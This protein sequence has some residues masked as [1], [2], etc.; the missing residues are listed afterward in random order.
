MDFLEY[1]LLNEMW[2][3][4]P[5]SSPNYTI[6]INPYMRYGETNSG[7]TYSIDTSK[8]HRSKDGYTVYLAQRRTPKTQQYIDKKPYDVIDSWIEIN[9]KKNLIRVMEEYYGNMN[10]LVKKLTSDNYLTIQPNTFYSMYK[11][12]YCPI[13]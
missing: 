9:C 11:N 7:E 4:K 3:R 1:Q 12:N 5:S 2:N 13:E 6:P 10:G 8:F